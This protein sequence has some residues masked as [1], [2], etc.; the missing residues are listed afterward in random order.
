MDKVAELVSLIPSDASEEITAGDEARFFEVT[1]TE[2]SEAQRQ[3]VV[4]PAKVYRG[5]RSVLAVHWHPEFIPMEL[6]RRRI[7]ATFPQCA[8]DLIIPTQHNVLMQYG[9]YTGVEVDC[10]ASGFNQKV[11]L[12]LHFES[13]RLQGNARLEQ[14]LDHTLRYRSSQLFDFIHT[15][16]KPIPDRIELAVRQTGAPSDLVAF[17]QA[18]V[19]KIHT[20]LERHGDNLP[21]EQ[22]KNKILRNYFDALRDTYGD[23]LIDRC[24]TFLTAVKK[25]VK[26]HFSLSYFY[27][28]SEIIE[29][30]RGIGGGIVIPHPEQFWP[31]LLRDYDVDGVEVWNPQSRRYTEFLISVIDAKNAQLRSGQRPLLILMGDDTHFG[32]KVR[33]P[34]FQKKEKAARE[35]GV[36]PPWEDVGI[37]KALILA[38]TDRRKVIKAYKAR[39]T[40]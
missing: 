6:I 11:Q 37:R 1:A 28:A 27:R 40:E 20:L 21:R 29:E 15:L 34:R 12:L 3:R 38:N 32:E 13:E 30:A 22:I 35:V 26:A 9:P 5:Q 7:D 2:L 10:Y 39:L 31:I 14:I 19:A 4:T 24:Q 16:I 25:I 8:D 23:A 17:V 36:Q 18:T 33:D